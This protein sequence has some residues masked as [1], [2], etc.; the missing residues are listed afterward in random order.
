MGCVVHGGNP[1]L[2]RRWIDM[3]DNY[4][5]MGLLVSSAS[6]GGAK[7]RLISCKALPSFVLLIGRATRRRGDRKIFR[8]LAGFMASRTGMSG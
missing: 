4:C 1:A 8:Y 3:V 7:H 6:A 2:Q 5:V